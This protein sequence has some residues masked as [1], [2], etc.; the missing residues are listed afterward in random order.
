[1]IH[2]ATSPRTVVWRPVHRFV[3]PLLEEVGYWPMVGTIGWQQLD[4]SDPVKW[5]ALL[6]AAQHWALRV[7]SCQEAQAQAAQAISAAADWPAVSQAIRRRSG[8]YIP[9]KTA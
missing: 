1:M 3:L 5:A 9:R 6:D 2:Q 7:E 8:V 4:A